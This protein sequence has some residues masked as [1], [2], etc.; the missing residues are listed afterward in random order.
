MK[1]FL[2]RDS[3]GYCSRGWIDR[4]SLQGLWYEIALPCTGSKA[5]ERNYAR[6]MKN[7]GMGRKKNTVESPLD[8]WTSG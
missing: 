1:T 8:G 5:G 6:W 4:E 7:R 2:L 3:R